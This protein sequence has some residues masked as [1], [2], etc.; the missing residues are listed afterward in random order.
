ML[1]Y[2]NIQPDKFA[3]SGS[4]L[5]VHWNIQ[6]KTKETPSGDTETYWEAN[7]AVCSALDT[8]D[9]LIQKIISSEYDFSRELATINN[10]G[11]D[12]TRYQE[13]RVL[14]KALADDWLVKHKASL[15]G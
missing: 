12:Y 2:S 5:R 1:V 3:I 13:F 9:Q 7:E 11:E 4:E 6:Q 15:V 8:R 10:G 14:A